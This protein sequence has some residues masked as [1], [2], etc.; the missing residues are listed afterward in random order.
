[1][2][3]RSSQQGGRMR[4]GAAAQPAAAAQS[5]SASAENDDDLLSIRHNDVS[6]DDGPPLDDP[7]LQSAKKDGFRV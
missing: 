7:R 5:A 1:M 3:S 2:R 6:L 4:I